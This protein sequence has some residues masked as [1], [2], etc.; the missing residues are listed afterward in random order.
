RRPIQINAR[1]MSRSD[2]PIDLLLDLVDAMS[3]PVDLPPPE[4]Q[5]SI[6]PDHL[7]PTLRR[8]MKEPRVA[9]IFDQHLGSRTPHR[10]RHPHA[11]IRRV[12]GGMAARAR[13]VGDVV[14]R[15]KGWSYGNHKK[16]EG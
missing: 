3:A 12:L 7:E 2:D 9:K 6:L 5:P 1:P 15:A 16:E 14:A 4:Q 11:L 10:L 8:L 13:G